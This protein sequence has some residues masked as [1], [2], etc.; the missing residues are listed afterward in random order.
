MPSVMPTVSVMTSTDTATS[1]D[2]RA[3][4]MRRLRMSRPSA[5]APS[6]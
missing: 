5:S 3:P 6:R 4:V 1:S 2:T